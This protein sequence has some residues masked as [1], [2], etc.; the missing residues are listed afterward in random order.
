MLTSN[1]LRARSRINARKPDKKMKK[2]VEVRSLNIKP[3]ARTQFHRLFLD[4]AL[5]LLKK[6]K[7]DVVAFGP[8][9]HDENSFYVIRS[10][11]SLE[12]RQVSEDDYYGSSDWREGPREDMLAL[13]ESYI[14]SVI[15]T[16]DETDDA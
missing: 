3:G 8:S 16:E 4:K 6:W 10:F 2:F 5:P 1:P 15:E 11:E 14:D 9:P 7:M 12:Q 13:T